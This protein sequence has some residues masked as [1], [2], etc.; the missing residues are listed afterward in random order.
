VVWWYGED[1]ANAPLSA[2]HRVVEKIPN[3][4]LR[5]WDTGHLEP[6]R[7]HDETMSELLAR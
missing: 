2:V 6:Y 4:G 1:D 3:V 5:V 7:R